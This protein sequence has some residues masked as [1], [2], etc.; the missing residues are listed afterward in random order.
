MPGYNHF[1]DCTCGWCVAQGGTSALTSAISREVPTLRSITTPNARCPRCDASVFFY[2]APEGGRVYFDALGPPWPKHPCMDTQRNQRRRGANPDNS[3][4]SASTYIPLRHTPAAHQRRQSQTA[5]GWANWEARRMH[6][7]QKLVLLT[8]GIPTLPANHV[9]FLSEWT[10][11]GHATVSYLWALDDELVTHDVQVWSPERYAEVPH[12]EVLRYGN[13]PPTV[14]LNSAIGSFI[15]ALPVT[16]RTPTWKSG[17]DADVSAEEILTAVLNAVHKT[18]EHE[19]HD[20]LVM[21]DAMDQA[22]GD[23]ITHLGFMQ[24]PSWKLSLLHRV[25]AFG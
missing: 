15:E 19:W 21:I 25:H 18:L 1:N 10:A 8:P 6:D 17:T 24:E 22:I 4:P 16:S 20:R 2:V 9:L 13:L 5:K 12:D 23:A 3:Q 11:Q 7:G 14:G